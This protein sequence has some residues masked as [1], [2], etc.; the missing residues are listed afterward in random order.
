MCWWSSTT[1]L[2][3]GGQRPGIPDFRYARILRPDNLTRYHLGRV[4]T[5][6]FAC[7]KEEIDV[8]ELRAKASQQPSA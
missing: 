1:H 3:G 5:T 4:R 2:A 6:A 7:D 8:I